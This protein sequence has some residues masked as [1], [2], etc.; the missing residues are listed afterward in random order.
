MNPWID[1][2]DSPPYVLPIDQPHVREFNALDRVDANHCLQLD[3]L[4]VPTLGFHNAPLVV[5]GR[6]PAYTSESAREEEGRADFRDALLA[7]LQTGVGALHPGLAD[8]F[9]DTH[10]A[11]WWGSTFHGVTRELSCT[12]GHLANKVLAVEF[13][14]Y[15]SASWSSLPVTLPSSWFGFGLVAQA[16]E[17]DAVIVVLR[18]LGDWEVAVPGLREYSRLVPNSHPRRSSISANTCGERFQLVLEAVR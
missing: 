2:P 4:P 9:A 17:R 8:A 13:H 10:C 12:T 6:N 3:A 1:I 14:G 16:M 5:L 7:N 18:G 11:K 15:R